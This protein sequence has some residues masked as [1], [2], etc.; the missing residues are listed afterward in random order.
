MKSKNSITFKKSETEG[1]VESIQ[2]LPDQVRQVLSEARLI[3]I[4]SSYDKITEVVVNGMG[5]SNLGAGLVKAV[6]ADQLKVPISIVPGY[7]VPAH[8][9]KNT[10]FII[11][12]YSGSTEEPLSVY[13]EVKKRGAKIMAITSRGNGK[14]EKL[15]IKDNIPGYIFKPEFNP[16]HQP[17]LGVGYMIFGIAVMLAK[18]GVLKINTKEIENLISGLEI[19]DRKLRPGAT[20]NQAKKIASEL[21][22][23]QPVLIGAEFLVGN[24]RIMR[25]QLCENSKN[26][27][28]YLTLPELNHYA[29]ESLANPGSN[30]KDLVFL[31]LDSKLYN[32]R[33]QIRSQLTKQVIKK[34]KIKVVSLNLLGKTKLAQTFE[35][36]Q[37]GTWVTFYL[38]MLNKVNPAE[39]H[40]VDWFKKQLK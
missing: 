32:P 20:N 13:N 22:G 15:M 16:S 4:P 26:F 37:M 9:G 25:N 18:A 34:N 7:S 29:L 30:K 38:A 28:S 10:L 8:V 21:F 3:K 6:F 36:L 24:L 19:S 2:F 27:A 40:W 17:R 12:S 1:V 23:L 14:L 31:F 11:S 33:V 35:A 5:G 39:I